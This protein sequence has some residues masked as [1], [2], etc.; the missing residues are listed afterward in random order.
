MPTDRPLTEALPA[1]LQQIQ[2]PGDFC[3]HGVVEPPLVRLH[4]AGFGLLGLPIA[5]TQALSLHALAEDAPYG[6]GPNTVVD[7]DVRRCRQIDAAALDTRDPRWQRTLRDIVDRAS[8]ALG[9][10]GTVEATLYK[11]LVYG[12]GDFFVEHRDTEKAPGMFA[13]LVVALPSPHTGGELVVQHA[14]RE[15]VISLASDDLGVLR[16]AAFYCDCV[17]ALKPVQ[18]G[19]RVALVYNL[20]RR[21]AKALTVPDESPVVDKIAALL[22]TWPKRDD[23]PQKIV[24]PLDHKYTLAELSFATLKQRDAAIARGLVR[25]GQAAGCT[26]LLAILTVHEAGIAEPVYSGSSRGRYREDPSEYEVVE[27]TERTCVLGSWRTADDVPEEYGPMPVDDD[28]VAPPDALEDAEPEEDELHEAMGNGG[29]S[30]ERSYRH[31]ALV[32]WPAAHEAQLVHAAGPLGDLYALERAIRR[33]DRA[34]VTAL[35]AVLPDTW[36]GSRM[37]ATEAASVQTRGLHALGAL[38][39]AESLLSFVR[40]IAAMGGL[41]EDAHPEATEALVRLDAAQAQTAAEVLVGAAQGAGVVTVARVLRDA[42]LQRTDGALV[43][44]V[45]ALVKR[46]SSWEPGRHYGQLSSSDRAQGLVVLLR[47]AHAAGG[48]ALVTRVAEG[49]AA[50]RKACPLD[51]VVVLA[52]AMWLQTPEHPALATVEPLRGPCV[53]MLTARVATAPTAPANATREVTG[54]SCICANCQEFKRFLLDPVQTRWSLK[55]A[56]H[57]RTHLEEQ[58]RQATVDVA[59]HTETRG[60]PHV[61]VCTKTMARYEARADRYQRDLA[62]LRMLAGPGD[63]LPP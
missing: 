8:A 31:T 63:G 3:G 17:H 29:A 14:G 43:A 20:T 57:A 28:E 16:W 41:A 48:E 49:I 33:S 51:D 32:V 45:E 4:V 47:A 38:G 44:P 9:V 22:R 40:A 21:G 34:A 1:L 18:Q 24:Y 23:A 7:R 10:E 27:E 39:D 60:S 42:S 25:A 37:S 12:P 15:E 62:A 46:L 11:M 54:L 26:V 2:R 5:E 55:A 52:L 30:Y 19:Y 50:E 53:E 58:I 61:L 35:A 13:T 56:Q 36:R 6:R 59:M